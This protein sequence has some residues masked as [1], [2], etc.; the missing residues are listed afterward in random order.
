MEDKR[1]DFSE[2]WE[3]I[4]SNDIPEGEYIVTSFS[5]DMTG[6]KILLSGEKCE[7]NIIFDGIPVLVRNTIEGIRMKTWGNVQVKYNDRFIFRKS[8]FFEIKKSE[9][10]KW[11]VEESCGFY[12]ADRLRHYCIVTREEMIDIISNF[13]PI[14]QR[15]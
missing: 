8:F 13:D 9:L 15:I 11:C 4:I 2:E 6:T 12:D 7:I 3:K 1:N 10:I 5:Q 14:I